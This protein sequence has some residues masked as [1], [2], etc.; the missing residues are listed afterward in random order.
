MKRPRVLPIKREHF[1]NGKRRHI[2]SCPVALAL[3]ERFPN[4]HNVAVS[5]SKI[6]YEDESGCHWF[7]TP[8]SLKQVAKNFDNY[9]Y[10]PAKSVLIWV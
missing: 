5:Y 7:K 4:W 2:N 6:I 9:T 8:S 3:K 1:K 10:T